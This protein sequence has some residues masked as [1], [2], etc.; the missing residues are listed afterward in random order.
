MTTYAVSH[1]TRYRY[2]V[3]AT[4]CHNRAHLVPRSTPGQRVR[5]AALHIDPAPQDRS[6]RVD[7]FGNHATFF[8]IQSPHD[9]LE[10]TATSTVE[11]GA[12]DRSPTEALAWELARDAPGDVV[13]RDL[14][15]ESPHVPLLAEVGRVVA[16]S[17]RPGRP[18]GEAAAELTATIFEQF[19][20]EPGFTTVSTP[21]GDV[22]HH[23]RGVCQDFAHL[24]IACLRSLGLA[25]RYVSG[26]LETVPTPGASR[27]Q[28]ADASHAW[29]A[30][31]LADG[32]WLDLDPTNG[33]VA[34]TRHV[35]VA[36]GRDYGDV[37]P[38]GGVVLSAGGA[39]QLEV[40]V[41]VARR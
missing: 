40:E 31:R 5:T 27:L 4:L 13:D 2:A 39:T 6:D 41:D 9:E 36:W 18:I 37:V 21:L 28:G 11:V 3:A 15:L 19:R 30:V 26:Y 23:R 8:S 22:L 12:V 10:I 38:V 7:V 32:T 24:A 33:L 34:P 16:P 1:T 14:R 25:A 20:Y 35:T 17:F 29:C